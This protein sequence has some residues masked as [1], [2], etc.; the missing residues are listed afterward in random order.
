MLA[1]IVVVCTSLQTAAALSL[2]F[3]VLTVPVQLTAGLGGRYLP[4]P[5]WLPAMLVLSALLLYPAY[6]WVQ[7]ISPTIF[8]ALGVYLPLMAVT[9]VLTRPQFSLSARRGGIWSLVNAL[10]SAAGFALVAFIAG[11]IREYLGRGALWDSTLSQLKISG[12]LL[13]F[14]GFI[15]VGFLAAIA[16]GL[17]LLVRNQVR[18]MDRL[19]SVA[20]AGEQSASAPVAAPERENAAAASVLTAAGPA[21]PELPAGS[22]EQNRADEPATEK[23]APAEPAAEETAA[24]SVQPA[25]AAEPPQQDRPAEEPS[26]AP[27]A[28]GKAAGSG[29]K[30]R[31]RRRRPSQKKNLSDAPALEADSPAPSGKRQEP[32]EETPPVSAPEEAE[33]QTAPPEPAAEKEPAPPKDAPPPRKRAPRKKSV[34]PKQPSAA[35]SGWTAPPAE[36]VEKA[37]SGSRPPE[38]DGWSSPAYDPVPRQTEAA[39]SPHTHTGGEEK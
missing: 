33:T 39:G 15:L 11:G 31:S 28:A 27:A 9:P 4:K 19:P 22:P 34:Q 7:G 5:L 14:F 37:P 24:P 17:V 13:P 23:E 1:P 35:G 2:V 30:P 29:S 3:L 6:Y 12:V 20:P 18:R 26:A 21:D 8:D 25:A 32:A 36:R 38:Q 10:S 16:K